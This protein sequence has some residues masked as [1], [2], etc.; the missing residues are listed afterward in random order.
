M[1][2]ADIFT[3]DMAQLLPLSKWP[4][5]WRNTLSHIEV[6][7]M[8]EY[9][10]GSKEAVGLLKKIRI[11]DKV[12]NLELLGKHT[13]VRCWDKDIHLQTDGI[14]MHLHY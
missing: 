3:D 5:V 6:G 12:K 4:K 11:P 2:V 7:E 13:T 1:D 8:F 9:M 14:E 10:E